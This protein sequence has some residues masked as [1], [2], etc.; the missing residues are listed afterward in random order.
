[1]NAAGLHGPVR[2]VALRRTLAGLNR[3]ALAPGGLDW[4]RCGG[5]SERLERT[6]W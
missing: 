5:R 1:M 2:W 6:G 3:R 4:S